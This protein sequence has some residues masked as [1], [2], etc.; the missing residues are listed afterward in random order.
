MLG[1]QS[2][3]APPQ[4]AFDKQPTHAP[5]AVSQSAVAPEQRAW[6]AEVHST[7]APARGPDN[8]H[9]GR[10]ESV[11]TV[12]G[13]ALHGTHCLL[14]GSQS[15]RT[16]GQ[17]ALVTHAVQRRGVTSVAQKGASTGHALT[18]LV[19]LFRLSYVSCV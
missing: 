6:F 2:G 5:V 9:A 13:E 15:G 18:A 16:T 10:A 19:A 7:Q 12:A 1:S 14:V 3:L 11:H 4:S 17:F 8:A